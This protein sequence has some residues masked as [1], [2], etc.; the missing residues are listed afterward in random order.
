[1]EAKGATN[2]SLRDLTTGTVFRAHRNHG[3]E[4]RVIGGTVSYAFGDRV[5][6]EIL[7]GDGRQA[8][9]SPGTSVYVEGY[10]GA[11]L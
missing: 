1:M 5:V 11:G 8:I 2:A 10:A 9:L 7:N 4:W 3:S 6:C